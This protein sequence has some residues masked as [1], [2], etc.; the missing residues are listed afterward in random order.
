[1]EIQNCIRSDLGVDMGVVKK[2]ELRL[3]VTLII[4]VASAVITIA[5][6]PSTH[7][8]PNPNPTTLVIGTV[9]SFIAFA[10]MAYIA[11]LIMVKGMEKKK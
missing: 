2:M 5:L 1:M 6:I 3:K 9:T 8:T 4:A 7:L 10:T 11:Y